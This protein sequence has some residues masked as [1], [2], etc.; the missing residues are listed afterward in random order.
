MHTG[1]RDRIRDTDD[2][3]AEYSVDRWF[4]SRCVNAGECMAAA[5]QMG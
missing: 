1:A 5:A 2:P 3:R 4:I